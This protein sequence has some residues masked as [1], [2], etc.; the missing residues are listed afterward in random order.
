[1]WVNGKKAVRARDV[2]DFNDM[3]RIKSLDKSKETIYV[4]AEAVK[5]IVGARYAEMVLHEMW[6]VAN[7]RI[8]NNKDTRR[9]RG[10]DIPPTRK[11]RPLHAPV[12]I[13]HGQYRRPQLSFLS[14]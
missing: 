5:K 7:L 2:A 9:Q 14:H 8:K 4:P 6:C 11:P 3:Y 13:T 1:M 12:A 10:S